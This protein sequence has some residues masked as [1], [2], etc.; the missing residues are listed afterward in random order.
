VSD[1][2][3]SAAHSDV[4]GPDDSSIPNIEFDQNIAPRPE[5]E[6]ADVARAVPDAEDH[7]EHNSSSQ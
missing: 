1:T 4:P 6:I 2:T 3:S 7:G 5:E